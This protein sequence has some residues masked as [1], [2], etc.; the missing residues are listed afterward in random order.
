MSLP[1]KD[2]SFLISADLN[3]LDQPFDKLLEYEK[4]I[5]KEYQFVDYKIYKPKRLE[6]LQQL[7]KNGRLNLLI[8]HVKQSKP[9]IGVFCGSFNPF[10][11]GH[12]NVLQKAEK[13]FDK[14][15]IAFG[16]NPDKKTAPGRCRN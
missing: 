3:I 8:E 15:I 7:N 5:F 1:M 6:V 14:V 10:H 9:L 2:H 16:K 4:Q 11:K 12:Y 13:I